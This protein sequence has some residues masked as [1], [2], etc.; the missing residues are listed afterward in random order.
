MSASLAEI[1][2][3]LAR[4]KY[5]QEILDSFRGLIN[6][7]SF[8]E[9]QRFVRVLPD[10]VEKDKQAGQDPAELRDYI[11]ET[12]TGGRLTIMEC[13]SCDVKF[14]IDKE[15]KSGYHNCS[16]PLCGLSFSVHAIKDEANILKA[17]LAKRKPTFVPVL[18]RN[19]PAQTSSPEIETKA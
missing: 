13:T 1:E 12:L 17:V 6:A 7:S 2:S 3:S 5:Q 10:L 19:K 14:S 16:C 4:R 11:L 15:L 8:D 18:L 9:I